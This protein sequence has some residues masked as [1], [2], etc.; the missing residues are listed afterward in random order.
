MTSQH[1]YAGSNDGPDAKQRQ[2]ESRQNFLEAMI[3]V[4]IT[5]GLFAEEIGHAFWPLVPM[6]AHYPAQTF[7][8]A[9][10]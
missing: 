6:R 8:N 5:D 4:I 1:E 7:A 10:P 2:I 3:G 9:W